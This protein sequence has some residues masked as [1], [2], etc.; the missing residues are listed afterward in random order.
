MRREGEI[1]AETIGRGKTG[2]FADQHG[3]EFSAENFADFVADR[4]AALFDN[5][6]W[7]E[8]P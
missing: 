3:D 2:T 7:R 4:D 5:D 1:D 6:D 8:L